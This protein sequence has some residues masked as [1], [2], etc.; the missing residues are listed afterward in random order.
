MFS[1]LIR[2]YLFYLP[3]VY[4]RIVLIYS[5]NIS[6][7]L[8]IVLPLIVCYCLLW[9]SIVLYSSPSVPNITSNDIIN[10]T[11]TEEAKEEGVPV[12]HNKV[13]I[14]GASLEQDVKQEQKS[15]LDTTHLFAPNWKASNQR[16]TRGGRENGE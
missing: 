15:R 9:G 14:G 12:H 8:S 10:N 4:Y 5:G 3:T 16:N 6:I 11:G 2:S 7:S 13:E 1:P